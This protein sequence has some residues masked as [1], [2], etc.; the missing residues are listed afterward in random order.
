MRHFSISDIDKM[1]QLF[2]IN[3]I[4]SCSGFKSANLIGT[5]CN[6]NITNVA[7]FSSMTHL[8]SNPPLLGFFIR[9][10]TVIRNTYE[11]IKET[12]TFTINHVHKD[13]IKEAHHTSAKY[14]KNIS[15]F[16]MTNLEEEYKNGFYAPY[17]KGVPIQ[18]GMKYVE[19]YSI[20]SNDTILVIG[21][22][23]EV[24]IED[25]VLE[26]D[27]FVNLTKANVVAING[28]DSYAVPKFNERLDYQRPKKTI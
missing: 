22:I 24:Y 27:G 1:P 16:D 11:N 10:T 23:S 6:N 19:E 25:S 4:N 9:P 26:T 21:Q 28:L 18:L 12:G 3:L 15:E 7:I 17:V 2:R 13:I 8:S 14:K 5:R 20:K